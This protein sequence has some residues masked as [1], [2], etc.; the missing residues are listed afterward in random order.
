MPLLRAYIAV[1]LDGYVADTEGGVGWLDPFFTPEIDFASFQASI[2]VTVMGRATWDQSAERGTG[3]GR[4]VVLTHREL[5]G[6]PSGIETFAGDVRQLARRLR[7]E[8]EDSGQDVWLLGGGN[9]IQ[10]FHAAGE[11]DRWELFVIPVLLGDGIPLFPRGGPSTGRLRPTLT[12]TYSNGIVE[13]W[14]EPVRP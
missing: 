2:G 4:A 5:E 9:C 1:S 14:Y 8:L 12:R 3:F 13:L 11:V 7:E 10:S 6:A